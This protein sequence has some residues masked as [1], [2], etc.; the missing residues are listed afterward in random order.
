MLAAYARAVRRLDGRFQAAAERLARPAGLTAAWW[1]VLDAV[2]DRPRP[3]AEIARATGVTR[4]SVQRVADLL[5][6]RGLADFRT[7]PAHRRAKLLAPTAEGRAA[8]AAA[9]PERAAFAAAFAAELATALGGEREPAATLRALARL[10]HALDRLGEAGA[11]TP[12]KD[13]GS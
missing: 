7:N 13:T 11:G 3:V 10:A 2:R 1:Q 4:Q 12:R 6:A 9:E 8:L 5:A